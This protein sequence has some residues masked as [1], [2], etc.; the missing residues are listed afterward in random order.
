MIPLRVGRLLALLLCCTTSF[1]ASIDAT[2]RS[3]A[4][5]PVEDAVV[6]VEPVTA[7]PGKRR[8]TVTIEQR[9][10]EFL[11]Y[12]TVVE[13]GTLV[14]FPNRD[15]FK[16]HI[17]SFSPAKVFEIKL[18]AGKP[19]LPVL[20]DKPGEVALGCNIHDWMEAYVLVVNT[21]Y[22]GKTGLDGKATVREVPPGHYRVRVWH[23]RQTS[24]APLREVE[25]AAGAG[26]TRLDLGAD[27]SARVV[28]PKPPADQDKY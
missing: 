13:T 2:V 16:H 4:G 11:P 12:V 6:V 1:A 5:K 3:P 22:F 26:A 20:F 14:E 10:R 15:A 8:R 23:P 25:I 17:Y 27:V 24:E 7:L 21:P 9:D 19:V 28:K 18:Y